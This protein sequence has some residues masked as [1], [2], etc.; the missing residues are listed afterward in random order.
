MP[1]MHSRRK[2]HGGN[3]DYRYLSQPRG[4]GT[5][6]YVQV[7]VPRS[8]QKV[9]RRRRLV[10]SL[11]TVDINVARAA[12]W[13][14]LRDL[15]EE[16]EAAKH[17]ERERN[18]PLMR[19]A[20]EWREALART[21]DPEQRDV[22]LDRIIDRAEEI[23]HN[24]GEDFGSARPVSNRDFFDLATGRATPLDTYL[25]RWLSTTTYTD[26]TKSDA[27]TAMRQFQDWC[28]R[29]DRRAF[30]EAVD[31]RMASD[32]RDMALVAGKVHP[33]TANKKLSLLRQHWEWLDR[34]FGIRPNPWLRKSLPK[35]KPHLVGPD[36]ADAAERAFT[37]DELR[38]LLS[39]PADKELSDIMRIAAL[40]GMRLEE[41]GQLRVR[42]CRDGQFSITK[43][44]TPAAIRKVPIHP[45]LKSIVRAR[46]RDRDENEF[47]FGGLSESGW[48]ETRT[49]AVSKRFGY[50]RRR[51]GVHDPRPGARRSKV[52]FHSFRRWFATKAEEAGFQENIVAA[53]LGHRRGGITFGIYSS[54]ELTSLKR[55]CVEAIQ[56]PK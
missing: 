34:S 30:L 49:M 51:V 18:A 1:R 32:F 29:E 5:T 54:A 20:L 8:L 28:V 35:L 13:N 9:M 16:I 10:R 23:K 14:A 56:L 46:M 50:Y 31:D 7:E 42:D 22:Y 11:H 38:K 26:R 36:D 47:L 25:E 33:K 2:S 24:G 45:H 39:G 6:W 44:K 41:I 4:D 3:G 48:D 17:P 21:D 15:K 55:K 52:N 19:E 37:D 12:R 43:G 40:S 53:I 27:R